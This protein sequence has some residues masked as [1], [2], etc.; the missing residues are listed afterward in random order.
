MYGLGNG[1]IYLFEH[2]ICDIYR[3]LIG[4]L[5]TMKDDVKVGDPKRLGD[6]TGG[7]DGGGPGLADLTPGLGEHIPAT[8]SRSLVHEMSKATR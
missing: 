4:F 7:E 8:L 5:A 3:G 2:P 1:I 6:K